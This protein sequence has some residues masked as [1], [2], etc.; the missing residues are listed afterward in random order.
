M[1]RQA[2]RKGWTK[3]FGVAN[4]LDAGAAR[5]GGEC[6][7][8]HPSQPAPACVFIPGGSDLIDS[9]QLAVTSLPLFEREVYLLAALDGFEDREIA[10]RLGIGVRDVRRH[11]AA[12][13]VQIAAAVSP[14]GG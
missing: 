5:A 4:S 13:L 10:A 12:A 14:A 7:H 3:I 11:L 9:L 2:A 6:E 8:R 1:G